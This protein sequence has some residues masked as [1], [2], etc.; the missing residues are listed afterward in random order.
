VLS[1]SHSL[2]ID[3]LVSLVDEE[4][5]RD[6]LRRATAELQQAK[7]QLRQTAAREHEPIAIVGMSCRF[8]G[9]A[10]SPEELWQLVA[11]G[12]DGI[13]GFPVNRGWD[14]EGVYDPEPGKPGHSYAREGGFLHDAGDFDAD[15]FKISPREAEEIDPQQRLLLETAW[16]ALERAG[17]DP[18]SLKGSNTGVFAGMVYHDYPGNHSTGSI[19]SGRVAYTLGLEGPA[20]TV[21]TACSSSL[22]ALHLAAQALRSGECSLA[23]AGGVTVM[24]TPDAF[25]EFSSQRGLSPDGRC[26]SFAAAADG[27]GWAEG[28]GWLLVERLSEARRLG[29]PVLALVRGTAVNQDG[30][31]NGLLAPSGPSQQRVIRAALASAGLSSADVDVMEAHGTG[32]RLGDPIEAQA[33]LATYGQDRPA[34]QPLLLGSIKSNFGHAQAAAG[35]ASIIKMAAAMAHGVVPASLHIDRPTPEVDWTAGNI[36]LLT[37][38]RPW[39][40]TGRPR[41]AGVSSFGVS[42]TNAHVILEQPTP[43]PVEPIAPASPADPSASAEP[44]DSAGSV[45][46]QAAPQGLP[47][48]PWVV[49]A[50]DAKA[51]RAQAARLLAHLNRQDDEK[52]QNQDVENQDAGS[53]ID[54]AFSLATGRA[55]LPHRAVVVGAGRAELLAGLTALADGAQSAHLVEAIAPSRTLTAFLCTGQGSQRLGM[56]RQLYDTFGV[57]AA[58]VDELAAEF[59]RYLDRPLLE[60]IWSDADS[61]GRTWFTQGAVF[62]IDVALGR[63]LESWGVRPD[64]LAGHSVGEIAAAHLAGVF[65]A[66]D[67]VRLVAARGALMEE[68]PAGGA[69]TALRATEAEVTPALTSGVS[70]AAINGPNS[71]VISGAAAEVDAVVAHFP[72]RKSTKLR[73]SHAFHSPLMEPM[74]A[75]FG[76]VLA[77]LTYH[78]PTVPLVSAVTGRITS[79]DELASAEYWVNHVRRPVRFCDVVQALSGFGVST[80]LEIGPDAVLSGLGPDCLDTDTDAVF[81]P[82]LRRNRDEPVA[83][84][85]ALA[86]AWA[87]GTGVDWAAFFAGSGARTVPLPTYAFQ[88]RPYWRRAAAPVV[89]GPEQGKPDAWRYQVAWRQVAD[90]P[91]A[92][93]GTWWVAV[94]AG[95][96]DPRVGVLTSGLTAHG[97]TVVTLPIDAAAGSNDEQRA[98]LADD[99]RFRATVEPPAGLL[100]LLALDERDHAELTGLPNGLATTVTL[101]QALTDAAIGVPTWVLTTAAVAAGSVAELTHPVQ[102]QHWGLATGLM[103]DH[104][105]WFAGIADL[106]DAIDPPAVRRLAGLLS[107]ERTED[108]VAIRPAG[109]LARRMV[110]AAAATKGS[111]RW[112]VHGTVLITGGTGG[113]GAQLARQL[114][115][116]GAEH[117]VLV[118]RRGR[119]GAATDA[120]E[121]ELVELGADVTILAGDVSDRIALGEILAALPAEPPLTAVVHAAGAGQRVV[122]LAELGL[123]EFADVVKAKITGALNLDALLGDR[124]LDA[125]VLF[126]SGAA[127]WGSTGQAGYAA[128]NAA[129]DALA[130]TRQARGL[131][132]TSI[133]WGPLDTGLVDAEVG[134]YMRRVGAPAMDTALALTA[135]DTAVGRNEQGLVIADF[136]W[137]RF[138]PVYTMARPRPLLDALPE[139][140]AATSDSGAG[141]PQDSGL[142]AKLAGMPPA[143]QGQ[144]LLDLVRTNVGL[145]LGYDDPATI[146]PRKSFTDL[147]FDSALAI[148]LR[149]R[150]GSATGQKLPSTLVFDYANPVA[151][152]DFLKA[153]LVGA[154]PAGTG[155]DLPAGT[156]LDRLDEVAAAADQG[157]R[158]QIIT[159]LQ[160]LL[161]RL[162]DSRDTADDT[163]LT[164][165]LESASADDVFDFIDRELGLA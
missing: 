70:I 33:L 10:S 58:T 57:F 109:V 94:P 14:I 108:Q 157:G 50:A 143:V 18:T 119:T 146:E 112:N 16:E 104:P 17:I 128:A 54:T 154:V 140:L 96:D 150:L 30:A 56:G 36:E 53:L 86:T 97:A 98:K 51:L 11:T 121:A 147:G 122:P 90:R 37:E 165:R 105:D 68:L 1:V 8:P 48:V 102:A 132:A 101:V 136:D 89:S 81:A 114:A 160:S 133:A 61:L 21:D 79:A 107:G 145:V 100:S 66:A 117:L 72:D 24:A 35:V 42:G 135:L 83:A 62:V 127:V 123:A 41:R 2:L 34:D 69:M 163:Q 113:V 3:W 55:A 138:G 129:M 118:S 26:R 80:F 151:L 23:L 161:T 9:G 115:R 76:E 158:E 87:R 32:T 73:V 142:A 59:D 159:R 103:L 77:G 162:D 84:V 13:T 164:E 120:L 19:A 82:V 141:T 125:F 111:D 149:T 38:A 49:T 22:V 52:N 139:A 25:I 126:S 65:N 28:V 29:H 40:E 91:A 95:L 75:R 137:A 74:L 148:D 85:T 130:A 106:P 131:A 44:V 67:A 156:L 116:G 124:K 39:P 27:T 92:L 144:V 99:L 64:Y 31:S 4:K 78:A 153:Q 12:S 47:I 88:R 43:E 46:G 5:L 110:R 63:L 152:A 20:V 15:F 155:A 93:T 45:A 7:R 71:L 60:V 134:E 6:Y